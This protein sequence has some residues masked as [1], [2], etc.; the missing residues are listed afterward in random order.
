MAAGMNLR[1]GGGQGPGE[2][3]TDGG[4]SL[5][6]IEG[7]TFRAAR[8]DGGK[9]AQGLDEFVERRRVVSHE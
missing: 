2:A 5:E 6:E 4:V 9:L 1:A 8:P 3:F 7:V